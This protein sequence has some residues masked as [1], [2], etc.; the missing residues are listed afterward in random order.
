MLCR[1]AKLSQVI[2]G[3]GVGMPGVDAHAIELAGLGEKCVWFNRDEGIG[4]MKVV[5]M[6]VDSHGTGS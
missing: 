5:G 2:I 4:G 1:L 3:D 6:C